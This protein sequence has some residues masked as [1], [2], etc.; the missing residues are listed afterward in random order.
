MDTA[1][2]PAVDK[3][4]LRN[5]VADLT[6]KLL[7]SQKADAAGNKCATA[8][9]IS[10]PTLP[11]VRLA[12]ASGTIV[13]LFKLR[14]ESISKF[15]CRISFNEP[16]VAAGRRRLRRPLRRRRQP[17]QRAHRSASCKSMCGTVSGIGSARCSRLPC[18]TAS[19]H[20]CGSVRS[21]PHSARQLSFQSYICATT[22]AAVLARRKLAWCLL[23]KHLSQ[24][25][26]KLYKSI[27]YIMLQLLCKPHKSIPPLLRRWVWTP[28]HCWRHSPQCR[29][30]TPRFPSPSSPLT[31]VRFLR[32]KD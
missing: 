4:A 30:S 24:P 26:C 12:A 22:A 7:A 13:S 23:M 9:A 25:L 2:I 14:A 8:A 29:R 20:A 1:V 11:C 31:L 16:C 3:A 6:K 15:R 5:R 32:S 28:R 21:L 10:P 17:R 19:G 18:S 27:L